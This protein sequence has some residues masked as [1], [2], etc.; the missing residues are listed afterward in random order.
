M[1]PCWRIVKAKFVKTAFA[2]DGAK[3]FPGRWNERGIPV[4]Y[5]AGNMSL[6]ILETLVHLRKEDFLEDFRLIRADI[7]SELI[8]EPLRSALPQG[9]DAERIVPRVQKFGAEWLRTRRSCVLKVPS[10]IAPD[11]TNLLL[12]PRHRHF[13]RIRVDRATSFT[14]DGRLRPT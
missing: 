14:F 8:E 7:P 10:A 6:A 9:W 4:I 2:G 12:N 3:R 13:S 1:V 5:A 11:D